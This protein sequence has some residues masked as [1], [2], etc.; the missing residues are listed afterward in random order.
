MRPS[1]P[2]LWGVL[3]ILAVSSGLNTRKVSVRFDGSHEGDL[4]HIWEATGWC[5]PDSQ[6]SA[7]A[8]FNYSIQ[9]ANWQNH[10]FISA[11][12]NSGIKYVRIHNL[13]NLVTVSEDKHPLS[14]TAYNFTLLDAVLDM[15]VKEHGLRLGFEIMGNPRLLNETSRRGVYTSWKDA[16]QLQG[17][18]EMVST[19]VRRYLDRYTAAVVSE[20]RWE[21]WNEPDHT[22]NADRK[23]D[24]NITCDEAAWLGY[25]DA[26]VEGLET[27][28]P[29]THMTWGGPGTGRHCMKIV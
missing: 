25:W 14:S 28:S 29:D 15:V 1:G 26:C 4:D 5:P 17:W 2:I 27:G 7:L 6:S 20:W 12:P 22:C 10:A 3:S 8:M 13:L 19:L 18:R 21:S 9:E 11:V 24:A 16:S 23:M